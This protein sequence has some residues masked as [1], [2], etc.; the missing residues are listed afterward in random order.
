MK[1]LRQ[2]VKKELDIS[3]DEQLLLCVDCAS[4]AVPV[5]LEDLK[6]LVC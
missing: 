1:D 4:D 3:D 5:T 6:T 2:G